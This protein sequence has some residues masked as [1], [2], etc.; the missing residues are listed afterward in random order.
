MLTSDL[1]PALFL[2]RARC[3]PAE[4]NSELYPNLG[5]NPLHH[6]RD[7]ECVLEQTTN[8]IGEVTSKVAIPLAANRYLQPYQQEGAWSDYL[9]LCPSVMMCSHHVV[10]AY[11]CDQK[12]LKAPQTC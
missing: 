3:Y 8:A 6:G 9:R 2:T 5:Q 1:S 7:E 11:S 4:V 12:P 10:A